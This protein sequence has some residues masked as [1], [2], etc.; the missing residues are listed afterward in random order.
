MS[1]ADKIKAELEKLGMQIVESGP[2]HHIIAGVAE[3]EN[4]VAEAAESTSG[5][6]SLVGDHFA[7]ALN[8]Q[9]DKLDALA[10]SASADSNATDNVLHDLQTRLSSL[11]DDAAS[12]VSVA[13]LQASLQAQTSRISQLEALLGTKSAAS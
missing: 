9:A 13:D 4:K 5:V 1:I 2:F 11:A 10:S 6:I 12:K 8:A 3:L 7:K